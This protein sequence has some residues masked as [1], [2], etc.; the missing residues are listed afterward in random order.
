MELCA[1]PGAPRVSLV[2]QDHTVDNRE[3]G[4]IMGYNGRVQRSVSK[5]RANKHL[6]LFLASV[7]RFSSFSYTLSILVVSNAV[8][9]GMVRVFCRARI[10]WSSKM[11]VGR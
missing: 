10:S 2:G 8:P 9:S 6:D 3:E 4:D 7:A 11:V 1:C 5:S